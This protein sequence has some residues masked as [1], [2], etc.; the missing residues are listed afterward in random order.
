M[1]VEEAISFEDGEKS[2]GDGTQLMRSS[3]SAAPCCRWSERQHSLSSTKVQL[4]A[5][6]AFETVLVA[7]LKLPD[8]MLLRYVASGDFGSNF[9]LQ[10]LIAGGLRPGVDIGYHYGLLAALVGRLWFAMVGATLA[11]YMTG[12]LVCGLLI[13]WAIARLSAEVHLG[14]R[15]ILLLVVGM[16]LAV[17][18]AY[19]NFAHA[20]EAALL[21]NAL[22]HQARG[23]LD[24]ALTLC[25]VSILTKPAMGFVYAIVLAGV[26]MAST[27]SWRRGLRLFAPALIT[28]TGLSA[29]LC[30]FYGIL[31][32][33]HT[34]IPSAG[35]RAY[36][37]SGFGNFAVGFWW[38]PELGWP[39]YM[40][41]A[42]GF[43]IA[44]TSWLIVR[45]ARL[46]RLMDTNRAA[47]I[48]VTCAV[49][50]LVFLT[51]MFGNRASWFYYSYILVI[52]VALTTLYRNA[53]NRIAIPAL[54]A[55]ALSSQA[56]AILA[57]AAESP[58]VRS[59]E[60]RDMKAD[61]QEWKEWRVARKLAAGH[62]AV[63]LAEEGDAALLFPEFEHPVALFLVP[64]LT[65]P[66][67]AAR[68]ARQIGDADVV[69]TTAGLMTDLAKIPDLSKPIFSMKPVF[70]GH[71]LDVYTRKKDLR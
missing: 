2:S 26:I 64:G 7:A 44:S 58:Y 67:E 57:H 68:Q 46:L 69:V 40:F 10:Y 41:T 56:G 12:M 39:Y 32:L 63:I 34:I 29:V 6:F 31:P 30:I 33:A 15:G 21:C 50:H 1:Q 47:R 23:R 43:W 49:L 45:A 66:N 22:A 27:E 48:I 5:L 8:Q 71:Y 18:V 61:V 16:P 28:F 20:L 4:F 70:R 13:A 65:L 42:A 54:T 24:L 60:T 14:I 62:R 51:M 55:L 9:T 35:L 25:A 19:P 11:S 53:W 3:A 38:R 36:R 17:Q 37:A 52:G 59:S